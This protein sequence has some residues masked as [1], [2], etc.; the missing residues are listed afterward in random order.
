MY[1]CFW[2]PEHSNG[3]LSIWYKAKFN[4]HSNTYNC[5]G[6]Y[7]IYQKAILLGKRKLAE[8][9][10]ETDDVLEIKRLGTKMKN[11]EIWKSMRK[12]I[13]YRG[14]KLKFEQNTELMKK[15]LTT[16]EIVETSPYNKY[17]GIASIDPK[18]PKGENVLGELLMKIRNGFLV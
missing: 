5:A 14:N 3:Y 18:K 4:D 2:K 9:I 7:L 10:L 11:N 15:L 12:I 8:I 16:G 13:A 1:T 6:Q 17:W